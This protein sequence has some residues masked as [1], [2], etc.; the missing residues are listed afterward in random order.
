V[1]IDTLIAAI[2]DFERLPIPGGV[3]DLDGKSQI[4]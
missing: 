3:F 1:T 2:A 4:L